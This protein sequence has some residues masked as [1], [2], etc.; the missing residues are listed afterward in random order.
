MTDTVFTQQRQLEEQ[1]LA[2]QQM[3]DQRMKEAL[4]SEVGTRT[5]R[6]T[7]RHRRRQRDRDR[8][9]GGDAGIPA[10]V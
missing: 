1:M 8:T 2:Y 3:C 5:D 6:Q 10:D 7:D 9:G 4:D